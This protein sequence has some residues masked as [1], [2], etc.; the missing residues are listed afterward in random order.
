EGLYVKPFHSKLGISHCLR[1]FT[2]R[3]ERKRVGRVRIS[4]TIFGKFD[5]HVAGEL[6]PFDVKV[7]IATGD[8]R[9]LWRLTVSK[10]QRLAVQ[11]GCIA[12]GLETSFALPLRT[13]C[14]RVAVTLKRLKRS[15][16]SVVA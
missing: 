7:V 12:C 1:D 10:S 5:S 11:A 13:S 9:G 16:G 3:S 4:E 6:P 14:S 15:L 2:E 8:H